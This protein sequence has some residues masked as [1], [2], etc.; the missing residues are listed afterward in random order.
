[1]ARINPGEF[2]VTLIL[3]RMGN[4]YL[5][6]ESYMKKVFVYFYSLVLMISAGL[7]Y[8]CSQKSETEEK[9]KEVLLQEM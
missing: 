5:G 2:N 3:Q 6:K 1:L 8:G 7:L 9:E 4:N